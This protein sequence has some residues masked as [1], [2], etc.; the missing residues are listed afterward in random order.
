MYHSMSPFAD[1]AMASS[2][3]QTETDNSGG[4]VVQRVNSNAQIQV[5]CTTILQR[6]TMSACAVCIGMREQGGPTTA[7]ALQSF[8]MGEII[9]LCSIFRGVVT[10]RSR[11]PTP[12]ASIQ[13]FILRPRAPD[14]FGLNSL[15]VRIPSSVVNRINSSRSLLS[16]YIRT[17]RRRLTMAVKPRSDA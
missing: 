2:T 7:M 4:V 17:L 16:R 12:G 3:Q 9:Y 6:T 5:L 8:S 15:R 10:L 13:S 1:H 11:A 14:S